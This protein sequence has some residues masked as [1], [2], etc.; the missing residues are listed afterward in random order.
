MEELKSKELLY[1]YFY[2]E[3]VTDDRKV[4]TLLHTRY[5]KNRIQTVEKEGT[6]GL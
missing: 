5:G 1:I 6:E 2:R 4:T 3:T